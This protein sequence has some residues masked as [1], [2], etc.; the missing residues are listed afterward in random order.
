MA[1]AVIAGIEN[2]VFSPE[3]AAALSGVPSDFKNPKTLGLHKCV[4]G[5]RPGNFIGVVRVGDGDCVLRVDSKFPGMDYMKMF[6]RC[7]EHPTVGGHLERCLHFWPEQPPVVVDDAP[8][9]CALTAAAFLRELNELCVRRLRRN[10]VRAE[11]NLTGKAKGKIL[12]L[13]NMRRN[14]SRGRADRA[15]CAFQTVSDDIRENRI[16]RAALEKCAMHLARHP[17]FLRRDENGALERWVRSCRARLHGVAVVAIRP[18]DFLSA[19]TRGAFSHY[20]RPLRLARAV[21]RADGFDLDG[22]ASSGAGVTPFALNSAELF[23]R[24]A[25]LALRESGEFGGLGAGYERGNTL[26]GTDGAVTIRPDFW[27]PAAGENGGWILDAKYKPAPESVRDLLDKNGRGDIYQV[28][29]YS[30]HGRFAR[31]KLQR[32][33]GAAPERPA[34]LALLYPRVGMDGTGDIKWLG[35]DASFQTPLWIGRIPC[36]AN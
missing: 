36:P 8:E 18:G 27:R 14:L 10:F 23:E 13:E 15:L 5:V 16:L 11:E 29:A 22:G 26:G 28:V 17:L 24:W 4:G 3:H 34:E 35:P 6:L 20:R 7:A 21:L 12:P 1:D 30:R 9:F 19:R 31:E 2:R 32:E 33:N 25:E